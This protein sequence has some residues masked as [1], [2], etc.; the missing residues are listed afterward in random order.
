MV[1]IE[2]QRTTRIMKNHDAPIML[3]AI[4][5][6]WTGPLLLDIGVERT[7]AASSSQCSRLK[8]IW[9]LLR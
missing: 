3:N 7:N 6:G 1:C 5:N 8:E 9:E 2:Y 4:A